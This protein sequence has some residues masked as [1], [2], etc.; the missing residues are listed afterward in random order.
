MDDQDWR[1]YGLGF[2]AEVY[3]IED[4]WPDIADSL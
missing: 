4:L 3:R 2:S 1:E